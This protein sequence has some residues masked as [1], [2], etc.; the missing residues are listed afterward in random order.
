[1][2]SFCTTLLFMSCL[3]LPLAPADV[4]VDYTQDAGGVNPAPLNGL[5]AR[6]IFDIDG[7]H[8]SILLQN[9]STGVPA[10]FDAAASL[11]VSVGMNLPGADILSGNAALIGPAAGGIGAWSDRT[12][13][14]SVGEQWIWTNDFGGDLMDGWKHVLST[15]EGQ[16]A[17]TVT[18][19][20]GG[21]GTVDGPFGGIAAAPPIVSIPPSQPAVCDAILFELTLTA[22]LSDTELE[23]V[24][25]TGIV[26]FGS[27]QRYLTPA[28]E[29]GGLIM[30]AIAGLLLRR[31]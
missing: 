28:P 14:A 3:G 11:L 1:M 17:G 29:P 8:L 4:I 9:T 7:T 18:R 10:G 21:S 15:S 6:V 5:S 31:S 22:P 24:A 12:A 23:I 13:G 2:R 25:H 30:L 27:D 19:F 26:E 16:G 20:D